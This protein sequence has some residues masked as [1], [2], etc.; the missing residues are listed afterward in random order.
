[1]WGCLVGSVVEHL[2]LAQGVIPESQDRVPH[3]A[4]CM[5]PASLSACVCASLSL[6]VSHEY[7]KI[8]LLKKKE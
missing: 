3:R 1:M 5:E 7:I 8:K 4:R 2:P 6:C